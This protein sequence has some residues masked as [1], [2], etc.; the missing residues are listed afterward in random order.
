MGEIGRHY[1]F[2]PLSCKKII[3][4]YKMEKDLWIRIECDMCSSIQRVSEVRAVF[5]RDF[6]KEISIENMTY[7]IWGKVRDKEILLGEYTKEA[8]KSI[9]EE[10]HK[11]LFYS[12]KDIVI[13]TM[14]TISY[15]GDKENEE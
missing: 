6:N 14:P 9:I 10:I 1:L 8:C 11:R 15:K 12:E 3:A 7:P 13:F 2:N 5:E 4:R